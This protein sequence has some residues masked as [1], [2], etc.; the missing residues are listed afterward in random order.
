MKGLPCSSPYLPPERWVVPV[1][2]W[3]AGPWW[4]HLQVPITYVTVHGMEARRV[5]LCVYL[6]AECHPWVSELGDPAKSQTEKHSQ[7]SESREGTKVLSDTRIL[8]TAE[9]ERERNSPLNTRTVPNK[10]HQRDRNCKYSPWTGITDNVMNIE[11][12]GSTWHAKW[13]QGEA[14]RD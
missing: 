8:S 14:I 6:I 12:G 10:H 3:S 9:R 1:I 7:T 2:D 5:I 4:C 13:H 11:D